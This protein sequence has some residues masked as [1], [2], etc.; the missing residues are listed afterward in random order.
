MAAAGAPAAR[1]AQATGVFHVGL[2]IA[3]HP[4]LPVKGA[5]PA[6]GRRQDALRAEAPVMRARVPVIT[7]EGGARRTFIR[8]VIVY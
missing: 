5:S 6:A 2:R 7:G 3:P 8:L 4:V 1:A